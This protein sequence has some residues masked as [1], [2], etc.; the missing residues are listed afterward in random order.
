MNTNYECSTILKMTEAQLKLKSYTLGTQTLAVL[1]AAQAASIVQSGRELRLVY[2]D[3][4][5]G[6]TA[7]WQS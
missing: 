4:S 6:V 2:S 7:G 1:P 3:S 5:S